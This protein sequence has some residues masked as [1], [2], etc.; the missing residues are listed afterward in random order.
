VRSQFPFKYWGAYFFA[1]LCSGWIRA[2]KPDGTL[3]DFA[4]G[5]SQPVDIHA[6]S[7]GSLYY[8][9]RGTGTATG[10]VSRI[11][12]TLAAPKVE[13]TANGSDELVS[14]LSVFD[15]IELNISFTA[16]SAGTLSSAEV[17]IGLSTPRGIYWMDPVLGFTPA[18][19][20]AHVGPL[21]D[22]SLS[23]WLVVGPGSLLPGAYTWFVLIDD[24]ADGVPSGDYSDFVVTVIVVT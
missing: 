20:R 14:P 8:L 9:A 16:G 19:S 12:Y 4:S 15:S 3:I 17:Y 10:V 1:D 13:V 23:P 11:A 2:R 6:T 24:D 18:L 21:G 22:F 7:E 5:I